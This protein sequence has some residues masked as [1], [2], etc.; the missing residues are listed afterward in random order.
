MQ[1]TV[2]TS[3][4]V[5]SSALGVYGAGS[6]VYATHNPPREQTSVGDGRIWVAVNAPNGTGWMARTGPNGI[7]ENAVRLA[8]TECGT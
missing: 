4:T 7:G 3:P 1:L 8:D 6:I 2:R 5:S